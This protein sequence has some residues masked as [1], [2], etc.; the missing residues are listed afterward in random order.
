MTKVITRGQEYTIHHDD[1]NSMPERWYGFGRKHD[2]R[3]QKIIIPVPPVD[4]SHM[5][6]ES[7]RDANQN[8]DLPLSLQPPTIDMLNHTYFSNSR[9]CLKLFSFLSTNQAEIL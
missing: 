9:K 4:A 6:H 1:E 3:V 5:K 8:R 2:Q 7:D